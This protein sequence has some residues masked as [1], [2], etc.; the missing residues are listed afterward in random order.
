MFFIRPDPAVYPFN[1]E[2]IYPEVDSKASPER[3]ASFSISVYPN[4]VICESILS[5]DI[6]KSLTTRRSGGTDD[7]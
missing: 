5:A 2:R 3:V 1:L 4:L 6:I 7:S